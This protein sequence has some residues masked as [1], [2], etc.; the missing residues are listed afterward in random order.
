MEPL[1]LIME[2]LQDLVDQ[3]VEVMVQEVKTLQLVVVL[4]ATPEVVE[5]A[6]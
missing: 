5:V 3:V 2:E 4:Q 6:V 1:S